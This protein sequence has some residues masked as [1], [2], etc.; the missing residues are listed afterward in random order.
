MKYATKRIATLAGST[1]LA[2]AMLM[3]PAFADT[4]AL[5]ARVSTQSA[6]TVNVPANTVL[7]FGGYVK[8]DFIYDFDQT[9]GDTI[10]PPS[11]TIPDSAAND[12]GFRFHVRQSRLNITSTTQTGIGEVTAKIEWDLFGGQGNQAVSNS[13]HFR[14]RHAFIQTNGWTIGQYWTLFMPLSS[15]PGTVDFQG[16]SGILFVRQPQIRYTHQVNDMFSVAFSVENPETIGD[17][18]GSVNNN[19]QVP[20]FVAAV[21]AEG[22]WGSVDVAGIYRNIED[23]NLAPTIGGV[24]V[25][26]SDSD[27]GFGIMFGGIFNAWQGGSINGNVAWGEGIGRYVVDGAPDA[28]LDGGGSVDA[29]EVLMYNIGVTQQLSPTLSAGLQWGVTEIDD[30]FAAAT[31][32]ETQQTIHAS[33]FWSPTDRM[34]VGAEVSWN[35]LELVNGASEEATRLQTSVQFNF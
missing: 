18:G 17:S 7:T 31:A 10:F 21:R 34:T 5:D 16:P 26:G 22:A 25:T 9:Q 19:D 30:T 28:R 24:P 13:E 14:L 23:P 12:G 4:S 8:A 35:E 27:D 32:P 11:L 2:S 3:A 20:D 15:Y 29:V 6:G 1:A 33:L